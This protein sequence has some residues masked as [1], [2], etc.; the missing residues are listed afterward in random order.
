MS[1]LLVFLCL[2]VLSERRM[3][4]YECR[5]DTVA[6]C[7]IARGESDNS[8]ATGL[9]RG[10]WG[11]DRA[12]C[13]AWLPFKVTN[14]DRSR[15]GV[16]GSDLQASHDSS[17]SKQWPN[18]IS[19]FVVLTDGTNDQ[20]QVERN[21]PHDPEAICRCEIAAGSYGQTLA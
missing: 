12:P 18:H 5:S 6:S 19:I 1:P 17:V 11:S 4:C 16:L 3:V 13:A 2:V 14:Q 15:R 20:L 10:V 9:F 8:R 21:P 7:A